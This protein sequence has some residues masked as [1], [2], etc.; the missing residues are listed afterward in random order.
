MAVV[1]PAVPVAHAAGAFEALPAPQRLLDTRPGAGTVDGRF[2][3]I[4]ARAAGSMLMLEVAGRAGVPAGATSVV[5]NVTVDAAQGD[6]FVTVYPCDRDQPN[7]SNLNYRT[8]Q[9]IPNTVVTRL[10]PDGTACL[11]TYSATHL[12]VDVAGVLAPSAFSP[13]PA[14]QRLLDTRPGAGTADGQFAGTGALGADSRLTLQVAGRAGVPSGASSVVLNV[15]V[16]A[17]Q[18]DGFVTVFPCDVGPPNASNL[19]YTTG[20]TI[21]NAVVTR[22]AADGTVCLYT[23]GATHLIVDVTGVFAPGAFNP[24]DAPQ[25]LLDSR[26]PASTADGQYGGAGAQPGN[27]TLQLRVAGRVGVPADASAVV[28]NVTAVTALTGG[29]V[30]VHPRGTGLPNASNLNFAPGQTIP[31]LVIARVGA[32]GDVCFFTSGV[33]HLIVDVA[34]WLTGPPPPTSGGDCPSSTP[35]HSDAEARARLIVRPDLHPALGEDRIAVWVCDVPAN[36]T[37]FPYTLLGPVAVDPHA[38]AAWAQANVAPYFEEAS[39]GRYHVTFTA[40]GTIPLSPTEGP[41]DCEGKAQALTGDPYTNVMFTDTRSY[42]GGQGGPGLIWSNRDVGVLAAGAPNRTSRGFYVGGGS[43]AQYPNHSVVVHEIGHTLHWPHSYTSRGDE[44][45][46]RIDV[47][48]GEPESGGECTSPSP[49]GG[50]TF[51]QCRPQHT[52]AFN[53]FAS[54]WIDGSE[55]AIHPSGTV[56]YTLAAPATPGV[57]LVALPDPLDARSMLTVEARPRVGRDEY[58]GAEGVAIHVVDQ[59]PRG[60]DQLGFSAWRR[61]RQA[62]GGS[63]SYDHVIAVGTSITVHGVTI[64]VLGRSGNSFDVRVSGTYRMPADAFFTQADTGSPTPSCA[65]LDVR[66]ALER[67]CVR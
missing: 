49:Y 15:T 58:L 50:T 18:Q 46:N 29:F 53:R 31:N 4:G 22:L 16:D 66:R 10:A 33:T 56:N 5:L 3:G 60:A 9:T 8:G 20:V 35:A 42:G 41:W 2:A 34:G 23:Y 21:P 13:L 27:T 54:A 30:T 48:S 47:M 65:E 67:G 14:P 51:W 61:Q 38:L 7:A 1:V 43:T 55:V 12:I 24:L 25:R 40:L 28:L 63:Y 59:V 6:G 64:S 44:Y 57:Q 11:Y 36:T 32:G 26:A 45:D 19:N 17:A 62:V 37:V 52:L 39:R